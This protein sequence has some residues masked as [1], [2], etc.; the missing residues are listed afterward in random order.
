MYEEKYNYVNY[1]FGVR[2]YCKLI[3]NSSGLLMYSPDAG[4]CIDNINCWVLLLY[5]T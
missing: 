3:K 2:G 4:K 5:K 1:P